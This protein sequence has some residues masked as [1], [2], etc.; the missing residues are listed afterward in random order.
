MY[1]PK[2][3]TKAT[4][5]QRFCR[6][7]GTNLSVILD[8]I[9][10]NIGDRRGG[11]ID[12]DKLKDDLRELGSNLRVGFEE[13]RQ[14]FK[15]ATGQTK[16][17]DQTPA[18]PPPPVP[19]KLEPLRVKQVRGGSTRRHSLQQGTLS[20][21]GGGV[22]TGVFYQLLQTATESGLLASIEQM[23]LR[24]LNVP[25]PGGFIPIFQLLWVVGLIPVAKGLGHLVNGIFFPA[26]PEPGT[27]EVVVSTSQ[28]VVYTPAGAPAPPSLFEPD[29]NELPGS[30]TNEPMTSI[31]EDETVRFGARE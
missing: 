2:C 17:L 12:F 15:Q 16:R 5:G 8:A 24:D 22:A 1:C 7:C 13:A 11:A 3:A 14:G 4:P 28:R 23:M 31:T 26:K 20:I 6:T 18:A 27:K 19:V 9:D 30:S 10:D 29:T 25:P 21:L